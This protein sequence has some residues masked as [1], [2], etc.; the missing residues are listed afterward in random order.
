ME[1]LLSC[2]K[3]W[4]PVDHPARFLRA[5]VDALDLAELGFRQRESREGAANDA[6]VGA[7]APGRTPFLILNCGAARRGIQRSSMAMVWPCLGER[8]LDLTRW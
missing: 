4:V 1:M 6:A 3:D 5:F 7:S 8:H 2:F